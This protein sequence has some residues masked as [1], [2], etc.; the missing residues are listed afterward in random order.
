MRRYI[1]ENEYGKQVTVKATSLSDAQIKAT[2]KFNY[3]GC[4]TLKWKG[5]EE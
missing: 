3:E 4:K 2:V 1:I 5:C